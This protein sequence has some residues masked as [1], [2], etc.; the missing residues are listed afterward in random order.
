MFAT[1]E[2]HKV[3]LTILSRCQRFELKRLS[4]GELRAHFATL[5]E[6]EGVTISPEA[7]DMVAREAAGSV[8]DGLSL[9]DHVVIA[10][11]SFY[12]FAEERVGKG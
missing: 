5:A 8:R 2:L 10:E 6:Q 7:V 12:S 11:G 1:T 9:L 4:L 3:P